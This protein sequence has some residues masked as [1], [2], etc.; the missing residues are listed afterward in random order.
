MRHGYRI[1]DDD[2]RRA[3]IVDHIECALRE[4][5]D[6]AMQAA[7]LRE[8]PERFTTSNPPGTKAPR[9]IAP[10][11]LSNLSTNFD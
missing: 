11:S 4:H 10:P 2:E 1:T 5:A 6:E 8:H 9:R 3:E 7:L